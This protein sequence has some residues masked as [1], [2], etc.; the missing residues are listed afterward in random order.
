M[1]LISTDKGSQQVLKQCE[2][3][4]ENLNRTRFGVI[5]CQKNSSDRGRV[6]ERFK[7]VSSPGDLTGLGINFSALYETFSQEGIERIRT[8]VTSVP[9]LLMYHDLRTVFRFLHV[10]TGR[11][12]T[13]G[14]V[15]VLYID[16]TTQDDR[17]VSAI[18]QVCDGKITVRE[19]ETGKPELRVQGLDTQPTEW[20]PF[21][22]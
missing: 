17:T 9:T 21:S 16:P 2:D 10:F 18:A 14:G 1:I 5:D 8:G 19:D 7:S 12:S 20:T 13:L 3:L 22:L 11:V 6:A 4:C 15:G